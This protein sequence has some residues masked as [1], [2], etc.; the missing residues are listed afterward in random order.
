MGLISGEAYQRA[1][2]IV[3]QTRPR[4]VSRF[5]TCNEDIIPPRLAMLW[6]ENTGSLPQSSLRPVA[7]HGI[8]DLLG[9]GKSGPGMVTRRF[10]LAATGLHQQGLATLGPAVAHIKKLRPHAKT[11]DLKSG[12]FWFA[13]HGLCRPS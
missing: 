12:I 1:F 5:H 2:H 8:A 13:G 7:G 10:A 11:G 3:K 4:N 6:Q 9:G